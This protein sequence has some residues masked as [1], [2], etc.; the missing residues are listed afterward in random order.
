MSFKPATDN[1]LRVELVDGDCSSSRYAD[2]DAEGVTPVFRTALSQL[3]SLLEEDCGELT[4]FSQSIWTS[5]SLRPVTDRLKDGAV[6]Y[7]CY[8]APRGSIYP[9]SVVH[10][11]CSECSNASII[12]IDLYVFNSRSL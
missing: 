8:C 7:R 11:A 2:P 5:L 10:H 9:P 12:E 4:H 3:L 1:D 6:E